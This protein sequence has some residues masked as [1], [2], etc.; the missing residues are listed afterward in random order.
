M[1]GACNAGNKLGCSYSI[2]GKLL[3]FV[4]SRKDLGVLVD[5]KLCFQDHIC[6]VVRK[7]EDLASELLRSTICHS[8]I[9]MLSLFVSHIRSTM[10][11]CSNVWNI[12]YLDVRLLE[13]MKQRWTSEMPMSV[14]LL[15]WR[16]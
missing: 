6:S 13:N 2:D 5:S 16:D 14:I 8:S 1:C 15:M 11:L 3:K 7:V 9:F 12:G 4:T 10:N